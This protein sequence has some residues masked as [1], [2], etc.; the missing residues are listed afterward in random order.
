VTGTLVDGR[1]AVDRQIG[2]G[3][4]AD[5]LRADD[6]VTGDAVA[7]KVLRQHDRRSLARFRTEVDVLRRL[8]H[9]SVVRLRAWGAHDDQ[10]YLVLDLVEGPTLAARLAGGPVDAAVA[11]STGERLASAL[12]YAHRLGVVHRDV[13]PSNVLLDGEAALPRLADFGIA[14]LTGGTRLTTTG[15]CIG[16]AAYVAPEQL[17]GRVG[18]EADVYALGLVLIECLTGEVCFPGSVAEAAIARLHRA[19]AVPDDLPPWLQHTLRAMT[20]R[21]AARRPPI[22]AVATALRQRS[23]EPVVAVT[24]PLPRVDTDAVSRA[25]APARRAAPGPGAPALTTLRRLPRTATAT[26]ARPTRRTRAGNRT[27][28]PMSAVVAVAAATIAVLITGAMVTAIALQGPEQTDPPAREAAP[29]SSAV[30][31]QAPTTGTTPTTDT[32][33]AVADQGAAGPEQGAAG[34]EPEA[35]GGPKPREHPVH[36]EAKGHGARDP[37]G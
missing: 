18:P 4:M 9:P 10:P 23:V 33:V 25:P 11:A 34:P 37:H 12:A 20:H 1:Y 27:P 8:D 32:A 19:P 16:T 6:Q 21:E 22:A 28:W 24:G 14:R 26:A 17:E 13:K 31:Q 35:A 15:A 36:G 7:L 2:S 5:V 30:A 3:G 29:P